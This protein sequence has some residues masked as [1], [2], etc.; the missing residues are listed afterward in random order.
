MEQDTTEL[1]EEF[2]ELSAS[3][4]FRRNKQM[5]GFSGKIR[6]LTIVF[7]ELI[8]NSLD[9]C[10]E[11]GILP[12]ITIELKRLGKDH[13]L[14]KHADNG[15]GIPED[16]ITKVYCQMFAGS[17]FRNIQSRGQQGLGCSGCVLLS[18]MTTGQ[19]VKIRS[20]YKDGNELK[21]V[22]MTVKLD[23]ENNTGI[24]LDRKDFETDR[25][26]SGIEI[27]FKE[28][29]YSMSEQGA[30]EYIRRTVIGN[31][32]ARIVF[33]DPT[34]RKYTF[35]RATDQI[36]PLPKEVLPHPKGVT[37]DDI[38]NMCKN[39]N[40][41]RFK[42]LLMDSLSRVSVA[43]IKELE[44]ATGIDM[45][46]RPKSITWKEAEAVVNQFDQMKFMAPPTSGLKPIGNEQIEKGINEIL[47]PEY[48]TAITRK[49]QSYRGGVSFIVEAGIAYG[50]KAGRS[51]GTQKKA[52]IMRFANRVPLSFDQGS[53]AITEA[54]KS[55]DWR[56][57]GIRDLDNAPI[58]VF[59]NII[60]T[61]VPYLSTGKQSVAPEEEIVREVRQATMKIARKLEKYLRAKKAAKN[62]EMRAKVFEDL[63]PVILKQSAQLAERDI[64]EYEKVMDEVTHKAKI[65]D[66]KDRLKQ[67]E[68]K[69]MEI[70]TEEPELRMKTVDEEDFSQEEQYDGG[71]D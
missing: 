2:K 64:P 9:A 24:I 32:H 23:V 68:I 61:N 38:I 47:L 53:C 15:P 29:S 54:L 65:M 59:V 34:G 36:P 45:N 70:K 10:E 6:S 19:P 56:R 40:K 8:T 37:A 28:V 33:K 13:Y 55:I 31:P 49:P 42:N 11:A 3:E 60:S 4:F 66:M 51:V 25:T 16:Y 7:H 20:R 35:E 17:K 63:V 46:K 18:Q 48:S 50:G 41:K 22:E 52:E 67:P 12:D 58:T 71:I 26:G 1:F 62:E 69:P 39:T 14:L 21:G 43:K 30:Y 44:E 27:E 5:L 57:Y